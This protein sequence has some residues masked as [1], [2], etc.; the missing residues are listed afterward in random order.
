M[1]FLSSTFFARSFKH[2]NQFFGKAQVGPD[3]FWSRRRTFLMTSHFYGRSR[4]CYKLAHRYNIAALAQAGKLRHQKKLDAKDLWECRIEGVSNTLNYDSW[5]MREA[6]ARCGVYLD[7]HMISN[8]TL[9][10]PR[11]MRAVVSLAAAKT[12]Q[13]PAEGGL[14]VRGAGAG[15]DIKIIGDI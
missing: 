8:L 6:L 3:R 10:E 9:T 7:R 1:V 14:G 15:P 4:N 2:T 11:T 13:S 5:Y 12:S